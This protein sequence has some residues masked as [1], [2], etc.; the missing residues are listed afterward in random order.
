VEA[1]LQPQPAKRTPFYAYLCILHQFNDFPT[2]PLPQGKR[3]KKGK[4]REENLRRASAAKLEENET[5]KDEKKAAT[6]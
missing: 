5:Q 4:K 1:I 3:Q 2:V 6:L